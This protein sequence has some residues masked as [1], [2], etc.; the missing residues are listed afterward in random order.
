LKYLSLI[1]LSILIAGC[2]GSG[3][4]SSSSD[5]QTW[6]TSFTKL[7]KHLDSL[8]SDATYPADL[9]TSLFENDDWVMS[10]ENNSTFVFSELISKPLSSYSE[11]SSFCSNL[12]IDTQALSWRVPTI[13]ELLTISELHDYSSWFW[14]SDSVSLVFS[15]QYK[16]MEMETD[17]ICTPQFAYQSGSKDYYCNEQVSQR[18]TICVANIIN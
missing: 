11:A 16:T 10:K 13:D 17:Y 2:G 15:T 3:S 4:S 9:N 5:A 1:L 12:S 18:Y 7:N 8:P 14:S 6:N